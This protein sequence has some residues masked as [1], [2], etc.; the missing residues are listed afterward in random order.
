MAS[1]P[2]TVYHMNATVAASGTNSTAI[3]CDGWPI[4]SVQA[5]AAFTGTQIK[6]QV[7]NRVDSDGDPTAWA[8]AQ[9]SGGVDIG[10]ITIAA[11]DT[12]PVHQE[13]LNAKFFRIVCA[14]AQT[15]KSVFEVKLE[16]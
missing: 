4:A 11:S 12:L 7:T 14:T 13:V 1:L 15:Y 9:D 16:S 3:P 5:P 2:R 8:D 6:F 10:A